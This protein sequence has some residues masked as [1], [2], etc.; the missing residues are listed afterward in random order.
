MILLMGCLVASEP[1]VSGVLDRPLREESPEFSQADLV[2]KDAPFWTGRLLDQ[3]CP[4]QILVEQRARDGRQL[5]FAVLKRPNYVLYLVEEPNSV[6]RFGC[7][8]DSDGSMQGMGVASFYPKVFEKRS[9]D[10]V[11]PSAIEKPVVQLRVRD[12]SKAP[13]Q[14]DA[15]GEKPPPLEGMG[16]SPPGETPV[17][18]PG[19]APIEEPVVPVKPG[20]LSAPN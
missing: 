7:D 11:V 19:E 17:E 2:L 9:L 5:S 1:T 16:T 6:V 14:S 20:G 18:I 15:S 13:A 12:L 4:G 8:V 10:L 3:R